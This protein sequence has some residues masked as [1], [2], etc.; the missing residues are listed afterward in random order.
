[1]AI[2]FLWMRRAL[3]NVLQAMVEM[4]RVK[5]NLADVVVGVKNR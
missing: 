5:Y 3:G 2:N 1:M 4:T